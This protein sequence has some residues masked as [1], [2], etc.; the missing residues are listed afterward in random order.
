MDRLINPTW[1]Q[2]RE[3][4]VVTQQ[5]G[6]GI[7]SFFSKIIPWA[8]KAIKWLIP[9]AKK[10]AQNPTVKKTAGK[11][12]DAAV[13]TGID[14][15]SD[16]L[17][18]KNAGESL[19][20][21]AEKA[22]DVVVEG[23]QSFKSENRGKTGESPS[24]NSRKRKSRSKNKINSKEDIET[25]IQGSKAKKPKFPSKRRNRMFRS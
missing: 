23:M 24:T 12:A 3:F 10:V 19:K 9:A 13:D 18:N 14:L 1:N 22:R 25:A 11:L 21:N 15:V 7:L 20:K 2:K 6:R 4:A 5:Q 17:Q 16:A 8:K